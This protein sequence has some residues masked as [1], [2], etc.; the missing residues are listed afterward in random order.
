MSIPIA[1]LK[2]LERDHIINVLIRV[3]WNITLASEVLGLSRAG[4]YSKFRV[5]DIDLEAAREVKAVA[6]GN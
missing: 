1:T 3:N 4:L 2:E 5:H 6:I